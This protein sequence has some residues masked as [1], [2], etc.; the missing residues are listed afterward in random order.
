M[1]EKDSRDWVEEAE[2]MN[3]A[4]EVKEKERFL[5]QKTLSE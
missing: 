5:G 2:E 4:E 1:S 3:E